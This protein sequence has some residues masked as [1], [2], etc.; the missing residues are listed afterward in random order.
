[1]AMISWTLRRHILRKAAMLLWPLAAVSCK[2]KQ[3]SAGG[4]PE[5]EAPLAAVRGPFTIRVLEEG[6]IRPAET[7]DV[8]RPSDLQW[9]DDASH[10]LSWIAEEGKSVREGDVIFKISATGF[11]KRLKESRLKVD[12]A[13]EALADASKSARISARGKD[14]EVARRRDVRDV[15]LLERDGLAAP[16][17]D[18]VAIAG[19]NVE[20]AHAELEA[21][22]QALRTIEPLVRKRMM[23]QVELETG[24]MQRDLARLRLDD[25]KLDLE[26]AQRGGDPL[27]VHRAQMVLERAE[28]DLKLAQIDRE[29]EARRMARTIARRERDLKRRL[30]ELKENER[31]IALRTIRARRA[32]V[33]LHATRRWHHRAEKAQVPTPTAR[34]KPVK[35]TARPVSLSVR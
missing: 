32:G 13:R 10:M 11:E 31:Q 27:L 9:A 30:K 7:L 6:E 16:D 15:K 34:V 4:G 26:L 17:P 18:E 21:A 33:L 12:R 23:A 14:L 8:M 1:M 3:T 22:E 35:I 24:R 29:Q 19:K 2:G 28:L 20:K 5:G 25:R